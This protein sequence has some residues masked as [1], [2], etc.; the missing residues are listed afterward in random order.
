M[1]KPIGTP[2]NTPQ[3]L[4]NSLLRGENDLQLLEE[5]T[6]E[7]ERHMIY[8]GAVATALGSIGRLSF[9]DRIGYMNSIVKIVG[10]SFSHSLYLEYK[11]NLAFVEAGKRSTIQAGLDLTV[12]TYIGGASGTFAIFSSGFGVLWG[13][14]MA[15]LGV[16]IGIFGGSKIFDG[17]HWIKDQVWPWQ[18]SED[19]FPWQYTS[20]EIGPQL[21]ALK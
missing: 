13:G 18:R 3:T 11:E 10:I 20:I 12:D 16:G 8:A 2:S 5:K 14:P 1:T 6:R 19:A 17:L 7:Q 15:L 9:P 21:K 4:D